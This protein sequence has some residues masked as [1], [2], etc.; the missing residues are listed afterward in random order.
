VL[1]QVPR[2][3]STVVNVTVTTFEIAVGRW[4]ASDTARCSCP[5]R[6]VF[7][8]PKDHDEAIAVLRRAVDA[9]VNHIDTA[10]YYGPDVSNRLI[11]EALHT[12]PDDLVIVSKVGGARDDHGGWL[13]AQTPAELRSGVEV[14]LRTLELEQLGVTA[15]C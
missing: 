7:G 14:N 4:D 13:L 3:P 1:E 6:G 9:G 10:Q 15:C 5:G 2:D 11:R 8:P 12:Y